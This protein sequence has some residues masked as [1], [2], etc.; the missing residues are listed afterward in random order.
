MKSIGLYAWIFALAFSCFSICAGKEKPKMSTARLSEDEITIYRAV[1]QNYGGNEAPALNVALRT[2]PFEPNSL[3]A[4][5]SD[6][7]IKGIKLDNLAAI[8]HS[9]HIL[10][11]SVLLGEN[12]R[13]VDPEKQNKIVRDND[14]GNTIGEGK[15]VEDAVNNAFSLALFSMSEIGFDKDH[16]FAV[17]SYS[18]YC[19]SLCGNGS[20][21]V[22]EKIKSEWKLTDRNCGRWVS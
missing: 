6:G 14:P 2:Y 4:S 7:C 8:Q 1:L 16:H 17:V 3:P 20:T 9:F 22:F 15:S 18:F 19:G 11:P 5:I 13:L 10:T 12:L 21:L